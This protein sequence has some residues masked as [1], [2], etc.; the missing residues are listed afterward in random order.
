MTR[1]S[2][3]DVTPSYV[4]AE[5]AE[6]LHLPRRLAGVPRHWSTE[7]ADAEL[8]RRHVVYT[9]GFVAGLAAAQAASGADVVL[10]EPGVDAP[11]VAARSR[12]HLTLLVAS[13]R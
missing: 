1:L 5:V 12:A 7:E 11:P 6:V 8:A 10:D 2:I 13:D 3:S 9:E 4:A